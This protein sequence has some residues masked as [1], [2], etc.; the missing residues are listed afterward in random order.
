MNTTTTVRDVVRLHQSVIQAPG[1]LRPRSRAAR[2]ASA[3]VVTLTVD[4]AV[5]AAAC[6]LARGDCRRIV[7]H[8]ATDV[9]VVNVDDHGRQVSAA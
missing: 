4:P 1:A 7:V 9:R 6:A 5:W 3:G 2:H 8:S